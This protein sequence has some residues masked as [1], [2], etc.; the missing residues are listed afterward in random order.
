MLKTLDIERG[1]IT[2][3]Y[4]YSYY[5]ILYKIVRERP[6]HTVHAH[7]H[8]TQSAPCENYRTTAPAR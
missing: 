5:N 3:C 8:N 1:H 2:K 7:T 6:R 4:K